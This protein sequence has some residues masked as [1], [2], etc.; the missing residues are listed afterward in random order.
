M[1]E[2]CKNLAYSYICGSKRRKE[3]LITRLA[4]FS[5]RGLCAVDGSR[6]FGVRII[7]C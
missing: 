3:I 4:P 5:Q 1:E 6:V 2:L 7:H